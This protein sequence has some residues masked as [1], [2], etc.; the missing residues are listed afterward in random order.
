MRK[1]HTHSVP[2]QTANVNP[3]KG[4]RPLEKAAAAY[5]LLHSVLTVLRK[6]PQ[7]PFV[8]QAFLSADYQIKDITLYI[9][10]SHKVNG[11]NG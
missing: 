4:K 7:N 11:G 6:H 10:R 9:H 2:F 8:Q 1:L 5:T 3:S